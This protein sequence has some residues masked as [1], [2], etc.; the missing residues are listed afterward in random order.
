[1]NDRKSTGCFTLLLCMVM[2]ANT[3]ALEEPR[4]SDLSYLDKQYMSQQRELLAELAAKHF[5]RKFN[6]ARDNDLDLLQSILDKRLVRAEQKQ[7]LQ[8]MGVIMGD[9]LAADLKLR[10]VIYEDRQGRS[11][12]LRDGSSDTYLFPITMIS[13][14]WEVGNHTPVAAIYL[15]ARDIIIDSRPGL[16]FQ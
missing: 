3:L 2:A 8:A 16:P 5:G 14:R 7:E 9:L 13:R 10:W 4:I 1:M 15:K 12:A 11:R 6:G